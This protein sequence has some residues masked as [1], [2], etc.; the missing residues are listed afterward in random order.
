MDFSVNNQPAFGRIKNDSSASNTY[1]ICD[2]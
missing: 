2:Y 1:I